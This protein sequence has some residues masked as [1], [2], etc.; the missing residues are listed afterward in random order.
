MMLQKNK[1]FLHLIFFS[2]ILLIT[3]SGCKQKAA[4]EVVVYV[5]TDQVFSEPILRDFEKETG[6][7]VK[8]VYDTEETKSGHLIIKCQT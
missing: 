3:I 6:I 4:N 1:L 5:S 7:N 8:T 2:S